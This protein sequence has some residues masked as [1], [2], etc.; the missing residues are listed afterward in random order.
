MKSPSPGVNLGGWLV[1]EKWMTPS[2][3]KGTSAK[4]EYEL[5]KLSGKVCAIKQHHETFITE[6]DIRWL[7]NAGVRHLRV[8]VGF[9]ILHGYYRYVSA[10]SQ[11]DWLFAMA[12]KYDMQILLCL[13]AAPGPQ[14]TNDHSGSGRPGTP[15]WYT[16]TNKQMTRQVLMEFTQRYGA[17]SQLW[18]IELMNEPSVQTKWQ[19]VQL[20]LWTR[21]T[22]RRLRNYLPASVRLVASDSFSPR[23]WSGRIKNETL[24]VHHYQCFSAADRAKT[25]Y[26]E[27]FET[28]QN[29]GQ[30]Y[31]RFARQQPLIIGEWSATLPRTV[32]NSV[33]VK[34]YCR[35]QQTAFKS[36]D[37]WFFW[38]YKLEHT[39]SWN[40][41]HL[42]E[43]GYFHDW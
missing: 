26:D 43:R 33:T 34:Q 42:Y 16:R 37:V 15:G 38:S 23:L 39:G 22:I 30:R 29:A 11:L 19:Y 17:H 24:D 7:Q 31:A 21:G 8:P 6:A 28:L 32:Q 36:A 14:N 5:A 35:D 13:H 40:F 18:G 4:N 27:H 20:L 2:L 3:F 12:K 9:W 41:R 25:S 1:L 10:Q